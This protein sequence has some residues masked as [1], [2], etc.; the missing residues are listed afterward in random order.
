MKDACGK[1]MENKENLV[2]K[3][4]Y[5]AIPEIIKSFMKKMGLIFLFKNSSMFQFKKRN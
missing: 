1:A 2:G 4:N 3:I 5:A